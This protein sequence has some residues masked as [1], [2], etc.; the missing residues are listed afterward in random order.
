LGDLF[1]SRMNTVFKFYAQAWWLLGA[2]AVVAVAS[3]WRVASAAEGGAGGQRGVAMATLALWACLASYPLLTVPQKGA[4]WS[5]DALA[6]ES[7]A[8]VEAVA[9]LREHAQAQDVLLTAP[10]VDYDPAGSRLATLSGVPTVLG[11]P[12]HERQWG[13]DAALLAERE[14]D[15]A[16]AYRSADERERGAILRRYG[17]TWVWL[18]PAEQAQYGKE[19]LASERWAPW[20][21]L[22]WA[23]DGQQLW[24][25]R[26]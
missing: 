4:T 23:K 15:I 18:G 24:H 22:A 6:A 2:S 5:L 20:C 10:G 25:C 11:W 3:L 8:T 26:P 7:P 14:R 19:A 17:V 16:T 21:A 1:G 13:R 12:Q 9:W